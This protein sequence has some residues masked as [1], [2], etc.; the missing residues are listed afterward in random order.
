MS[1][2][3]PQRSSPS[4]SATATAVRSEALSKSTSTVTF[5]SAAE[6]LRER[7]RRGDRVAAVRRDQAVRD[8]AD[9]AAAPPRRL[10]VGRDAD[11]ARDV[12]GPAVAGLHEPVVV[13]RR[14]EQDRL[15]ARRLDDVA[16]VAH[17]QRAAREAAEEDRLE[18]GEQRVV[19][20]DRQDR[21]V[22]RDRVALV[23]RG[24]LELRRSRAPRRRRARRA[25]RR[26]SAPRCAS[27]MPPSSES[28]FWKT[29]MR[30]R[31]WR[32]VASSS[33]FVELK[34]ASL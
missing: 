22:R 23:E 12:R 11:R 9:A 20:L 34:Y 7:A 33:S 21:L 19:A 31:G 5:V 30:T 25:R 15:A 10:R 1:R 17:D 28:C 24:D 13:A 8:R 6:A 3:T 29:C 2:R 4:A 26:P 32:P 14:E 18:V 27:S 16:D